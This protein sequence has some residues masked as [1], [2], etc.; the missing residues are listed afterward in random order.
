MLGAFCHWKHQLAL[1]ASEPQKDVVVSLASILRCLS[2]NAPVG[3]CLGVVPQELRGGHSG[4]QEQDQQH[5]EGGVSVSQG[6]SKAMSV[7]EVDHMNFSYFVFTVLIIA[8]YA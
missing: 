4:Q 7:R 2:V 8:T 3:R 1:E 6:I 5:H